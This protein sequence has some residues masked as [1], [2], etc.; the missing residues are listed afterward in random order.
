[1]ET[2]IKSI[3]LEILRDECED[4]KIKISFDNDIPHL[5]CTTYRVNYSGIFVVNVTEANEIIFNLQKIEEN[6]TELFKFKR[7]ISKA[8][9]PYLKH[10][11]LHELRHVWQT[12]HDK[13]LVIDAENN[14]LYIDGYGGIRA[15]ADANSFARGKAS[16]KFERLISDIFTYLQDMTGK[17]YV[18]PK[19]SICGLIYMMKLYSHVIL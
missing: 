10:L 11:V 1:M 15:E 13:Q 16:N 3:I 4:E 14:F 17:I 9:R 18:S 2:I 6:I 19:D 5:A 12:K 7:L 8:I